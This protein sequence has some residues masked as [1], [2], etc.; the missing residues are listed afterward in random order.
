MNAESP[1]KPVASLSQMD[2]T[3]RTEL[4]SVSGH[5]TSDERCVSF[6]AIQVR[7]YERIIGDHPET[8]IGVPLSL[9]W[10][11]YERDPVPIDKYESERIPKK[12]LRMSSITRKN[13]LHNVYGI[14]EDEIRMAEKE[15]RKI[16]ARNQKNQRETP[17]KKTKSK[18]KRVGSK[19]R[20]I[21]NVE[22]FMKGMVAA[23]SNGMMLSMNA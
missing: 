19:F 4:S 8:K 21:V 3:D 7:E 16:S 13:I 20:N 2:E 22:N 15:V 6:G 12:T 10:G 14:P 18:M 5:S 1:L 11:Y 23:S 17:L 9:G